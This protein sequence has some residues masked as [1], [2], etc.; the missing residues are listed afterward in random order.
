MISLF[1]FF[2]VDKWRIHRRIISPAFTTYNLKQFF[3][4]YNDKSQNLI[5]NLKKEVGKTQTFDL[6]EYI[7]H[8]TLNIVC[9][10]YNIIVSYRIRP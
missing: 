7:V 3:T 2:P 1:I 10:K 9:R 6:W 5:R 8:T 4:V